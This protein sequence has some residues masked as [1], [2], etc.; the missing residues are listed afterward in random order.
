MSHLKLPLPLLLGL[1][2]FVSAYPRP[3]TGDLRGSINA[4]GPIIDYVVFDRRGRL[5][6]DA[7]DEDEI[8]NPTGKERQGDEDTQI[9]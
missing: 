9:R 8:C 2:C 6:P 5:S 4:T 1:S 3:D 7:A